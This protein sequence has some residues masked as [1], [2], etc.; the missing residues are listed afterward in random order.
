VTPPLV[1]PYVEPAWHLYPI[2]LNLDMLTA[3][4][5]VI[6]RALRAEN[7]GVQVHYIPV[8]LHPFYQQRFNFRRGQ[9]PVAERAYERLITLPLFPAMTDQDVVDVIAAVTKVVSCFRR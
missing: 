9:F 7:I 6:F 3:D 1:K 4:R 2:Q 8:H 5:A